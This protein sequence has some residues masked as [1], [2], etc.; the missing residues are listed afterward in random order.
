M[1][2]LSVPFEK[3]TTFELFEFLQDLDIVP[4]NDSYDNWIDR[5]NELLESAKIHY[6]NTVETMIK[7]IDYEN[8]II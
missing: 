3:W 5:R 4:H 8:S 6:Q 1:K 7:L 2:D